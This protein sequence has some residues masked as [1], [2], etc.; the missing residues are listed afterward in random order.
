MSAPRQL[1]VEPLEPRRPLAVIVDSIPLLTVD[2]GATATVN[3][4][5]LDSTPGGSYAAQVR[6]ST[7]AAEEAGSIISPSGSNGPLRVQ[8]DY[9]YD[10]GF[11]TPEMKSLL[12]TAAELVV[13]RLNDPLAG[14]TPT[15]NDRFNATF[16]NPATGQQTTIQNFSVSANQFI[17]FVAGQDLDGTNIAQAGAGGGNGTQPFFDFA[18]S[19]GQTGV[20]ETDF[21]PWGGSLSFDTGTNW[22]TGLS[23][24]GLTGAANDFL[25][26]AMHELSHILGFT[27]GVES[28]NRFVNGDRFNGPRAIQEFDGSG[29]PP[30]ASDGSHWKEGT[31][32]GGQE[33]ALDPSLTRGQRKYLTELDFAALDD[34]GWDLR[35]RDA[36]GLAIDSHVYPDN[37]TFTGRVR[38]VN[39]ADQG[40]RTFRVTVNNVAPSVVTFETP[41][42]RANT[43]IDISASFTDPGSSDTHIAAIVWGDGSPQQS[44]TVNSQARTVSGSHVYSQAGTYQAVLGVQDDDG[45]T[46]DHEFTIVV[47]S[48]PRGDWQNSSNPF[49]V[50]ANTA[51]DPLDALLVINELNNRV[52]S[53]PQTGLLP[54]APGNLSEFIDVNG[55]DVVAPQ[56]ALLVINEL[57]D[58]SSLLAA[59]GTHRTAAS[60]AL[61]DFNVDDE[62][63]RQRRTSDEAFADFSMS[64][65][66]A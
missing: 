27:S 38:V 54:P 13:G 12:E 1:K 2:E 10:S 17:V 36:T 22:H 9:R 65:L 16:Q 40:A 61:V 35:S 59:R 7:T 19:R 24:E 58:T 46:T 52:V 48:P 8:F 55:D 31:E 64:W 25:S 56:D 4:D 34:L 33:A 41:T 51:I 62:E 47:T 15:G 11:V 26:V 14:F 3:A 53:D 6:W 32:D 29:A 42:G 18:V 45:G 63:H 43:A 23:T 39:G 57:P 66:R 21:A 20:P 30:V 50:N 5:F 28:F 49:D 60:D 37:G 44:L